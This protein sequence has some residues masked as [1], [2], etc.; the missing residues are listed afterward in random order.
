MGVGVGSHIAVGSPTGSMWVFV[1]A[2][3]SLYRN[4]PEH[5]D[6]SSAARTNSV[7]NGWVMPLGWEE[8]RMSVDGGVDELS[9]GGVALE[10]L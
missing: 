8:A 4:V 6:T 9:V 5:G 3:L 10:P 2:I 1:P 7:A